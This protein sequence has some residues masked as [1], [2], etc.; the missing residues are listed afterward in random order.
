MNTR[1][2]LS[3]EV[4]KGILF[5]AVT[6]YP[7]EGCG[8][9]FGNEG[10]PRKL[11]HFDPV[12]NRKEGDQKRRFEISP[13]DYM[14]AELKSIELG[15][16]L[17]GI[18]HSHPDHPAVASIHDLEKALPFFSYIIVSVV[19]GNSDQ[20]CSWRLIDNY[21]IFYQEEVILNNLINSTNK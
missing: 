8:F 1:I 11:V 20:I 18:Y 12:K 14:C 15:L 19:K 21:R 10:V 17:L 7:N 2:N 4:L 16:E 9:L 13:V 3:E 6:N 5:N